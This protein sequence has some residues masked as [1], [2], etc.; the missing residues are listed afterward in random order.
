MEFRYQE[1]LTWIIPGFYL[2]VGILVFGQ[3]FKAFS[4]L[5]FFAPLK[6][7]DGSYEGI[8]SILIFLIPLLSF[9]VG[10]MINGI[11]G[12]LLRCDALFGYPVYSAFDKLYPDKAGIPSK[13][14]MKRF[15]QAKYELDDLE[16]YDRFYYRYIFSRNMFVAQLLLLLSTPVIYCMDSSKE[17]SCQVL[18]KTL[19][20]LLSAPVSYCMDSSKGESCQVLINTLFLLLSLCMLFFFLTYR[21]LNTHARYIFNGARKKIENA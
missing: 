13:D 15:D 21:D 8:N 11:A 16:K 9:I 18:I 1:T 10:W 4:V 17:E 6:T 12:F 20:L 19:F 2:A 5:D 3:L 7:N 14:K